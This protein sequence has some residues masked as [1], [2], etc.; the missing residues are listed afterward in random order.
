MR[1]RKW[2]GLEGPDE[3]KVLHIKPLIENPDWPKDTSYPHPNVTELRAWLANSRWDRNEPQAIVISVDGWQSAQAHNLLC[4]DNN[5]VTIES[6]AKHV[7][8]KMSGWARAALWWYSY[9]QIL[10]NEGYTIGLVQ[11]DI[12][13]CLMTAGWKYD[14]KYDGENVITMREVIRYM[15]DTPKY[16]KY[17]PDL[18]VDA[19][20]DPQPNGNIYGVPGNEMAMLTWNHEMIYRCSKA[21]DKYF[22]EVAK[23]L[24]PECI[25]TN[26]NFN[27]YQRCPMITWP[28]RHPQVDAG[29][30]LNSAPILY[31]SND[32]KYTSNRDA[33][34][35][36]DAIRNKKK[37][38]PWVG[39]PY[40]SGGWNGWKQS[41]EQY[42]ELMIEIES[43]GCPW[44]MVF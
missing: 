18:D 35:C 33:L 23:M 40:R 13:G 27:N 25:T 30:D 32:T 21:F 16:A 7:H 31:L 4:N 17:L 10:A 1:I 6:I 28:H 5:E 15:Y 14:L 12:E 29:V 24:F 43:R 22:A 39:A 8:E 11:M 2:T 36:L 34:M 44:V 19:V 20:V 26:Y 3:P 41:Q 42:D 38:V 37:C 9:L